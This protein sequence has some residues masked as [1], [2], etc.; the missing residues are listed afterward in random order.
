MVHANIYFKNFIAIVVV[1][2]CVTLNA[3][4]LPAVIVDSMNICYQNGTSQ[5]VK[6]ADVIISQSRDGDDPEH[7]DQVLLSEYNKGDK[8]ELEYMIVSNCSD[9]IF[10]SS[11]LIND[12]LNLT[13]NYDNSLE[14]NCSEVY[15]LKVTWKVPFGKY[16]TYLFNSIDLSQKFLDS[17]EKTETERDEFGNIIRSL[18]YIDGTL[19]FEEVCTYDSNQNII[20]KTELNGSGIIQRVFEYSSG[21]KLSKEVYYWDGI[22]HRTVNH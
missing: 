8:I 10:L 12:S 16:Y 2:Q 6:I 15:I 21:G 1:L 18:H 9:S 5:G 13:V 7:S 22:P 4:P 20:S 19:I 14:N 17:R 11:C 3:Q